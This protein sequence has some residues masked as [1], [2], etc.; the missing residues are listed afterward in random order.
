VVPL[1]LVAITVLVN[2]FAQIFLKLSSGGTGSPLAFVN[3][4]FMIASALY[5]I[6]LIT[7]TWA[8]KT[9]PLSVAYPFMSLAIIGV[10]IASWLI[11]NE[12]LSWQQWA[13][14]TFVV[15]GQVGFNSFGGAK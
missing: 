11:L 7:W 2:I 8:L 1:T 3:A 5:G 15:V 4:H 12:S 6:G 13:F 14:L 9:L 10:P